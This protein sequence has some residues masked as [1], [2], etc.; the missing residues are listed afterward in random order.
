MAIEVHPSEVFCHWIASKDWNARELELHQS[1]LPRRHFLESDALLVGASSDFGLLINRNCTPSLKRLSSIKTKLDQQGGLRTRNT[2]RSQRYIDSHAVQIQGTAMGVISGTGI[3]TYKRREGHTMKDALVER[4]RHKLR[5]PM[6]LEAFSGVEISLCTGN[7]RRRRLL[8]LLSSPTI[9][10]YLRG[11]TFPWF[12]EE[13]GYSYYKALRCPKSF[14]KFWKGHPEYRENVGDAISTCLDALEET[15]V[16]EESRELRG[17]WVESFDDDGDSDGESDGETN[18]DDDQKSLASGPDRLRS[19]FFEEWIVTLF[20]SEYTWTGFLEDSEESLTMAV[21][22]LECLDFNHGGYGRRCTQT[23]CSSSSRGYPV[24]QTSL[25]LNESILKGEK[26]KREKLDAAGKVAW[27]A[28]E[29]K[30]GSS[31][32]LGNHGTLKVLASSGNT[33]PVIMEW[34]GVKSETLK[35]VKNVAINEKLLGK[36][37]ERHHR[38]HIRGTWESKPLPVL[39]LSKSPK[40]A[41]SGH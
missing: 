26:L 4:W 11:I 24:F 34:S 29:V 28:R 2:Y 30:K 41:F 14:R 38:E 40:V 7:A 35:E 18:D 39:I 32:S 31:L 10:N 13:C 12:S 21:L 25:Q 20:R 8:H 33:C 1:S 36:N 17:F 16:N 5:N 15:G 6:D 9:R 23:Q 37:A 22:N 27:D 3:I 19:T